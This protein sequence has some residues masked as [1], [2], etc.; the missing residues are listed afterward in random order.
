MSISWEIENNEVDISA[1]TDE[2]LEP[3]V[4]KVRCKV[5]DG[6]TS[7]FEGEMREIT[8]FED[9][10]FIDDHIT[11]RKAI[12]NGEYKDYE[13]R[14]VKTNIHLRWFD[15]LVHTA[16]GVCKREGDYGETLENKHRPYKDIEEVRSGVN[17]VTIDVPLEE[18]KDIIL[19]MIEDYENKPDYIFSERDLVEGA[20]NMMRNDFT[21]SKLLREVQIGDRRADGVMLL[22]YEENYGPD[23]KIIG[24]EAKA[25][26]DD[27]SRL[28]DQYDEYLNLCDEVYLVIEGKEPPED[29]PFYVGVITFEDGMGIERG[30]MIRQAQSLKHETSAGKLWDMMIKV[31]NREC[32][33]YVTKIGKTRRLFT[34]VHNL[35]RK[36]IWNQLVEGY[37]QGYVDSYV[38]LTEDE[39][40]LIRAVHGKL[41]P[42]AT[43]E[44]EEI[45]DDAYKQ[46]H[47]YAF[48]TEG[49]N[50]G[51]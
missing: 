49:V 43:E 7:C 20:Y 47:L 35:K 6:A 4:I 24:I 33:A 3:K 11:V 45:I 32:G 39:K 9:G 26:T 27:Y 14:T 19:E 37:H 25:D 22:N 17:I 51:Q 38:D 41:K 46:T 31:F 42:V 48:K 28:Y 5:N 13:E 2:T 21:W 12:V 10:E 15:F 1:D 36:L 40:E 16:K 8:L 18:Y 34:M 23:Y 44:S 50:H 29:L 30:K